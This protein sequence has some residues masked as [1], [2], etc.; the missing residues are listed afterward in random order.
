MK[1]NKRTGR[2][3]LKTEGA[4]EFDPQM[5]VKITRKNDA[6]ASAVK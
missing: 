2:G 3:A 6:Q 5:N 4:Q 1:T